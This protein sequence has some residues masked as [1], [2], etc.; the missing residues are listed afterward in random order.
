MERQR[1]FG[2]SMEDVHPETSYAPTVPMSSHPTVRI[3]SRQ[4]ALSLGWMR[5]ILYLLTM[6]TATALFM[7]VVM[8]MRIPEESHL[9]IFVNETKRIENPDTTAASEFRIV[10]PPVVARPDAD[11]TTGV[12]I[13]THIGCP[14]NSG[15]PTAT[16]SSYQ[17]HKVE[18]NS[19]SFQYF[20]LNN[21]TNITLDVQQLSG[22]TEF[23]ILQ[24]TDE[25][26]RLKRHPQYAFDFPRGHPTDY[27]I[28]APNGTAFG[29]YT[30]TAQTIYSD[31]VFI[32]LYVSR[33]T[34]SNFRLKVSLSEPNF[35]VNEND[36]L[37]VLSSH[38]SSSTATSN[39][40]VWDKNHLKDI[41]NECI[42]IKGIEWNNDS[43]DDNPRNNSKS[44]FV[45]TRTTPDVWS[46]ILLR[47]MPFLMV[48]MLLSLCWFLSS[49]ENHRTIHRRIALSR[50]QQSQNDCEA[51][52]IA[53]PAES[54]A[55]LSGD[56]T[57][58]AACDHCGVLCAGEQELQ[59]HSRQTHQNLRTTTASEIN[60]FPCGFC[61][62]LGV[63]QVF[64]KEQ[65]LILHME[66]E[67]GIR[68]QS[69]VP[70][71]EAVVVQA[72]NVPHYGTMVDT[73][74]V[75][76][77]EEKDE[78]IPLATSTVIKDENDNP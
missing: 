53:Y 40:I 60:Q 16:D 51:A 74:D 43:D 24:G 35:A 48:P 78:R 47:G 6:T 45:T 7:G 66:Q 64:S 38:P 46:A 75:M 31:E 50:R 58:S 71:A 2:S 22:R 3:P 49:Q 14:S 63:S 61:R 44:I 19:Y 69:S 68:Y 13:Y 36:L 65:D 27:W 1:N 77:E 67:H 12:E 52:T 4:T 73:G 25:L 11:T 34:V 41:K 42:I 21:G 56:P 17:L 15:P 20:R 39:E 8:K 23:Y 10:L 32:I 18:H 28:R 70:V 33:S 59:S 57:V 9:E 30:M 37:K 5:W 62:T 54:T 29:N 72:T 76:V 55:F 26:D